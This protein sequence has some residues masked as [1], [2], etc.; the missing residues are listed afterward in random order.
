MEQLSWHLRKAPKRR[1]TPSWSAPR[2]LWLMCLKPGL[3]TRKRR[4]LE[5]I[6][7]PGTGEEEGGPVVEAMLE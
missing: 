7:A 2:E 6:G 5:G 4:R 1:G 3:C